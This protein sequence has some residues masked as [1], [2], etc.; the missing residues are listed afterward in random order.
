[1]VIEALRRR[2]LK[3]PISIDTY[4]AEVAARALEAGA[5][6]VND[7]SGLRYDAA[8]AAVVSK[9]RAGIVLMHLRG[10][11]ATMQKLPPVRRIVPAIASGLAASVRRALAAGIAKSRI[12][13]DPGIG[14][15]KS[16][17]QNFEI[18]GAGMRRLA[19][20]G[21]PI[22]IGPSRKSFIRKMME[23]SL[24]Q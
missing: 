22:L 5:E 12:V 10:M 11:P 6:I 1:P 3:I 21:Y 4:K 15:G 8:L 2:G 18:L 13:V 14:F 17:D 24:P 16:M 7:I 19:R 20:M 9:H 23:G